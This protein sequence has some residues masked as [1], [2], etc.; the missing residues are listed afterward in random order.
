MKQL[1]YL[2]R[3]GE[4][5]L[6]S[7]LRLFNPPFSPEIGNGLAIPMRSSDPLPQVGSTGGVVVGDH[8]LFFRPWTADDLPA[9]ANPKLVETQNA[10][11]AAQKQVQQLTAANAQLIAS[12]NTLREVV[13]TLAPKK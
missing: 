3:T 8:G 11:L 12:N 7:D 5:L 4:R 10:L 6:A 2:L 13:G 9:D 1:G